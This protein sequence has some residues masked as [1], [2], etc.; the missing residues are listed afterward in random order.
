MNEEQL[1]KLYDLMKV[2]TMSYKG[3]KEEIEDCLEIDRIIWELINERAT[4]EDLLWC[5]EKWKSYEGEKIDLSNKYVFPIYDMNPNKCYG[6]PTWNTDFTY[7]FSLIAFYDG[8]QIIKIKSH[9]HLQMSIRSFVK[10]IGPFGLFLFPRDDGIIVRIDFPNLPDGLK[11]SNKTESRWKA[12]GKLEFSQLAKVIK[13]VITD[14]GK[15]IK[16]IIKP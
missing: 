13:V 7:P 15:S 6:G 8:K 2:I 14:D 3:E 5:N 1:K 11:K 16:E 10:I 12:D 9:I 4:K